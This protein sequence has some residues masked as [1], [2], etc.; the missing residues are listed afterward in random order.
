MLYIIGISIFLHL[1]ESIANPHISYTNNSNK[2]FLEK[3]VPINSD[4]LQECE[5]Y[6]TK[7]TKCVPFND[8]ESQGQLASF[9]DIFWAFSTSN[10]AH[11]DEILI[12]GKNQKENRALAALFFLSGQ[13]KIWIWPN[14]NIKQLVEVLG[15]ASG[16]KRQLFRSRVYLGKMREKFLALK[17]QIQ[18]MKNQKW[19]LTDKPKSCSK[20]EKIIIQTKDVSSSL[21]VFADLIASDYT[22]VK[23]IID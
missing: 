17:S 7:K 8:F 14:N 3:L 12:Y 11:T 4:K 10:I 5:L 23:I 13:K 6:S 9:R 16:S 15:K 22:N 21:A 2:A 19:K 1:G 20:H 18:N